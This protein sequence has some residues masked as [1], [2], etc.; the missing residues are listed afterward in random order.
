MVDQA[1]SF[2]LFETA[3]RIACATL[4]SGGAF[5]GKI[6]Q[7]PD[8]PLARKLV[9]EGFREERLIR[10]EGTRSESYEIFIIGLDRRTEPPPLV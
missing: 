4:R 8:F 1:R 9:R 3:L 7:G 10:P 6:F 2:A 5:A